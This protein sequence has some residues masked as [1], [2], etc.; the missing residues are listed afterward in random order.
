MNR[1][2]AL[3]LWVISIAP[4]GWAETGNRVTVRSEGWTVVADPDHA[5]LSIRY[6][7]LGSVMEDVRFNLQGTSGRQ[8]LKSW[9]VEKKDA[10]QL[11]VRMTQPR[12]AWRFE[13]RPNSLEISSTSA[14]GMLT[15]SAPAPAS[16]VVA[17]AI[18]TE[19]IPVTWVGTDEVA[20]GYGG[21]ET[22]NPSFLPRRNPEC[23]Y[24]A[25]GQVASS[26][27]HSLFDRP[28][29][30]IISFSDQTQ[31][32]R[33]RQNL[34]RLD[35][36]IPVPGNTLIRLV[37]DYYTKVLGVPFYAPF[38]DSY[39]RQA[40]AVWSSW[41]SYYSEV[42]EQDIVRNAEWIGRNL[43]PYGFE[44][45]ELDE[46]YDG[47][48]N[49]GESVSDRA[50]V[51]PIGED[52]CWIGDWD[53]KKFPHGP[54]WLTSYIKA[55]GL[56]AGLWLVP[57]A[58]ACAL[59]KHPDWYVRDKEGKIIRDYATPALDS[60]NPEVLGFLKKLFTTLDDWGFEYYKFDGEHAL[61]QYV[62]ALDRNRLY[63]TRLIR[64]LLIEIDSS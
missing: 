37:P 42:K 48:N 16:R 19:G 6:D 58:Y 3:A 9:T 15:A 56:R 59:Q 29:D 38:D 21:S 22:R 34:D 23:M 14:Q 1:L 11:F 45:V 10:H 54:Q 31:M 8:E 36:T 17:R 13:L 18:D 20:H 47:E 28:S 52:H 26:N 46:G 57:N 53:R 27:F 33:N 50:S 4:T 7:N 63:D 62:P 44:Y 64:L 5:N 51:S 12:T 35:L 60:S 30:S 32:Q 40:P 25:L 43:K 24:F 41:T 55:Q 49:A 61:P 2:P 39:F